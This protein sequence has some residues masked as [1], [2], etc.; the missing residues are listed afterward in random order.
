MIK[1]Y[2]N[3]RCRKSRE[4]LSYLQSKNI[5][6]KVVDYIKDGIEK[7]E[8]QLILQKLNLKPGD[9]I[10]TQEEE[11]KKNLKNKK[12]TDNE[13]VTILCENPKL[14]QRPIVIKD[15]RAVLAIPPE[16]IDQLFK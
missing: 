13:W 4:G 12:F 16:N 14:L 7:S 3:P 8:L 2:H 6:F 11:Y 5:E 9:I 15:N 10:R 1:I